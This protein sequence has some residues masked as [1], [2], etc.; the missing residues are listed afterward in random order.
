MD[1][2][3]PTTNSGSCASPVPPPGPLRGERARVNPSGQKIV[4]HGRVRWSAPDEEPAL[5]A[6]DVREA[7]PEADLREGGG[8][9]GRGRQRTHVPRSVLHSGS[10]KGRGH[11]VPGR[12]RHCSDGADGRAAAGGRG[13]AR[14]LMRGDVQEERAAAGARGNALRGG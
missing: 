14:Y 5:G 7:A 8:R 2:D 12:V 11:G 3:T 9:D 13:G 4:S 6:V 10:V 1:V